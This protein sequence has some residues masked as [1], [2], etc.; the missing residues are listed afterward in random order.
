[1]E[2]ILPWLYFV[3]MTILLCHRAVRD[4]RR[5]RKKYGQAWEEYCSRV[6]YRLV[7]G[8]Y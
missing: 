1:V 8:L 7:P 5:C 3:Y 2:H 6:P 4:D